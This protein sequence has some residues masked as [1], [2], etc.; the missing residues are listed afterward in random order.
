MEVWGNGMFTAKLQKVL[1]EPVNSYNDLFAAINR[2]F[3]AEQHPNLFHYGNKA[4]EFLSQVPFSIQSETGV[5][6][7]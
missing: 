5:K 1:N 6:A 2:G 7:E 4:Y 3:T